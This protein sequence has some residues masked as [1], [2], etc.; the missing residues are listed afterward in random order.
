MTD[1]KEEKPAVEKKPSLIVTLKHQ[2][3]VS[4]PFKVKY[5]TKMQKVRFEKRKYW[6]CLHFNSALAAPVLPCFRIVGGQLANWFKANCFIS[7]YMY[8]KV[9]LIW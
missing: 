1:S 4:T 8:L 9:V 7:V 2:D 3:G 5:N 6:S